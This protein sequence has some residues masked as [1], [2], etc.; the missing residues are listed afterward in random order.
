MNDSN[1]QKGKD[2]IVDELKKVEVNRNFLQNKTNVKLDN[3]S[4]SNYKQSNKIYNTNLGRRS[5]ITRR[6]NMRGK[7]GK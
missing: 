2:I 6:M 7:T 4:F 5:M 1:D 3:K